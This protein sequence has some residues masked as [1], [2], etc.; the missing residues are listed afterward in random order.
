MLLL[1]LWQNLLIAKLVVSIT[2]FK[3]GMR[4]LECGRKSSPQRRKERKVKHSL[5]A[6]WRPWRLC[7][8]LF[9][10]SAFCIQSRRLK[11]AVLLRDLN[12]GQIDS[13]I[14]PWLLVVFSHPDGT[15]LVAVAVQ[16]DFLKPV[17]IGASRLDSRV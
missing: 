7:G 16:F 2:S 17:G 1:T 11:L 3:C 4:K 6:S 9:C 14:V 5:S 13:L 10:Y 12:H 8:A 15:I